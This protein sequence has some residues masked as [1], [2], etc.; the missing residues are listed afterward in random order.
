MQCHTNSC[1]FTD[2]GNNPFLIVWNV[3]ERRS[4]GFVFGAVAHLTRSELEW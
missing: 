3:K 4:T 1:D 2:N